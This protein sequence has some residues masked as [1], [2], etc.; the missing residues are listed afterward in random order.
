M[1]ERTRP[2][3]ISYQKMGL[4]MCLYLLFANKKEATIRPTMEGVAEEQNDENSAPVYSPDEPLAIDSPSQSSTKSR[5]H[6]VLEASTNNNIDFADLRK[7]ISYITSRERG[8]ESMSKSR[9]HQFI[10]DSVRV[11]KE[12][13]EIY[14]S[15]NVS[16]MAYETVP[17]SI[18]VIACP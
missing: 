7:F 17:D 6:D 12:N 2:V 11:L 10:V 3:C 4:K 14:Q 18:P 5:D 15:E 1:E 8:W 16:S 9:K 13:N